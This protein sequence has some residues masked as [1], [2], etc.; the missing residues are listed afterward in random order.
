[1]Y[2]VGANCLLIGFGM[3][4]FGGMIP[5]V[6][7]F[8]LNMLITGT[9][10]MIMI[11]EQ[12]EGTLIPEW[13]VWLTSYLSYGLGAGIGAGAIRWPKVGILPIGMTIGFVFGKLLD[14]ALI[15]PFIEHSNWS[16]VV[17]E[18]GLIIGC[19]I[20]SV[21]Y[22]EDA[23]I[24]CCSMC[25]SYVLF[26]G[27]SLFMG[28]YPTEPFMSFVLTN[29]EFKEIRSTFWIYFVFM[30]VGFVASIIWQL[31]YKSINDKLYNYKGQMLS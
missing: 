30:V 31:Y 25:G 4:G 13:T 8:L 17:F 24:V 20:V 19:C 7:L 5:R 16:H 28:G 27:I 3:V 6:S 12:M 10:F 2:L 29:G 9:F 15:E 22:L 1:M 26:R 23:I 11:Y 18:M 21:M 14:M